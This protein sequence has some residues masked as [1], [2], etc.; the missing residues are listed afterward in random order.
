MM[1]CDDARDALALQPMLDDPAL[2]THLAGCAGCT[3]YRRQQ[4]AL[5]GVLRTELAWEA[6]AALTARLAA[7]AAN[8]AAALAEPTP[9]PAVLA[10]SLAAALAPS[11]PAMI[12]RPKPW[13]VATVYLLTAALVAV[14]L[15]VAWQVVGAV[16]PQ[17][18]LSGLLTQL[19]ALPERAQSYINQ[20]LPQSR[21]AID[22]FLQVRVQ[23]MWLLLVAVLWAAL[24]NVDLRFSFR[25]RQI[26]L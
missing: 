13:I 23:L 10:P 9:A 17:F 2:D 8:P 22:L 7:L 21:Y 5:D 15:L 14:S 16:A 18:E 3:R 1:T 12:A 4:R 19:L 25:G 11:A 20:K 26:S 6:P 24:D